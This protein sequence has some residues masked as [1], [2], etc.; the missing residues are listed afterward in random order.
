MPIFHFNLKADNATYVDP[1]GTDLRDER[2]AL[3]HARQVARELMRC[4]ELRTRSWRLQICDAEH[5]PCIELPFAGID[6]ATA[7]VLSSPSSPVDIERRQRGL[8]A[9][10]AEGEQRLTR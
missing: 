3:D 4:Q 1:V 7:H 6:P 2:E 9:A 8:L 10:M 5:K